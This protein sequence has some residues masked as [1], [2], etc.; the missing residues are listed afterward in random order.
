MHKKQ[1][2]HLN[3]NG[4]KTRN[5]FKFQVKTGNKWAQAL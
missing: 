2:M 1:D 5:A 4:K 3:A